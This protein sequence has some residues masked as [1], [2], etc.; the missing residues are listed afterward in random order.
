MR[1]AFVHH[2]LFFREDH[3][4]EAGKRLFQHGPCVELVELFRSSCPIGE[5]L[6]GITLDNKKAT[7]LQ[8][9]THT[10]PLQRAFRRR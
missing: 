4:L 1:R 2:Q 6:W 9:S 7:G 8:R 10:G 5:L 3:I